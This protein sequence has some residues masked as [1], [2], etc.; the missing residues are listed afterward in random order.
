[1]RGRDGFEAMWV[2]KLV[3]DF[4]SRI[5]SARIDESF[6]SIY[7]CCHLSYVHLVFGFV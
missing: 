5:F 3:F 1:M 6:L 7:P 4:S 2:E